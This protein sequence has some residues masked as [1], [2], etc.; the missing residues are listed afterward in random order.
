MRAIHF[1]FGLALVTTP[2][3]AGEPAAFFESKIRPLLIDHCYSCHSSQA[4]KLNRDLRLDQAEGLKRSVAVGKPDESSIIQAVRRN[5]KDVPAMPPDKPMTKEQIA[6]LEE[7]VKTGAYVPTD[8]TPT[9]PTMNIAS[10]KSRWPYA[11]VPEV[12]VPSVRDAN[13]PRTEIDRFILA[14][15][16]S[17]E[18]RPIG[19]ATKQTLIRRANFDLIGLPPTPDEVEAFLADSSPTAFEKVIDRLLASPHYGE[20]WGR[21]WM[22][23]VRYSDTAGDNSDFPIP[24]MVKYRDWI[25]DAI[26]RDLPFDRFAQEQ[27]AGDLIDGGTPEERQQRTIATGYLANARRFGS[28]VSDYPWHL[29]I[30]DTIDNLG[31]AFLG[32]TLNCARCHDHKFDPI[33]MG[34][35]YALY[36]FF[37]STKYPWPGIELEQRQ[38]DLV[39]FAPPDVLKNEVARRD[40][41]SQELSAEIDRLKTEK[42]ATQDKKKQ[43]ELQKKVDELSAKMKME[44]GVPLPFPSAYAV[45]E[46]KSEDAQIQ[47]KGDPKKP[48]EKVRRRFLEVLG[49]SALPP[50]DQS[51]G[52]LAL[53]KWI[54]SPENPLFARVIVNRVWYHHFGR[55]LISTTNDFGKQGSAPTHPELLDYLTKQFL[56][57]GFSMKKLHKRLMLSRVYQIS[58]DGSVPGAETADPTNE[59]LGKFRLRRLDAESIR[60]TLLAVSGNLKTQRPGPHPFPEMTKWNYTQHNP[61]RATYD[62]NHRSVYLMVQR[63]QRHPFLANFDGADTGASTGSRV[64]ST[65]TLQ[66]LYFLNDPFVHEQARAL[67]SSLLSVSEE[68]RIRRLYSVLFTRQPTE[69]EIEKGRAYLSR[70]S[71]SPWESYVRALVRLNEFVYVE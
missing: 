1:L 53:A 47:N 67:A 34:D 70:V 49:G 56:A 17:K 52:R 50:S 25:I 9:K 14:K 41:L 24:Q 71:E 64:T 37:Q 33:S 60:D 58:S 57:E 44:L 7:W 8:A 61:F 36:G 29:T 46:S 48:G 28:T 31:R 38:R 63:I 21:H 18:L 6:F 65:T 35:Y 12:T 59:L 2:L 16:E 51:S 13:W 40:A 20:R 30:E 19:D 54:S 39:V 22:D 26:N 15:L 43:D 68:S 4:K 5:H 55:G 11:K 66:S 42:K 3:R 23:V 45:S 62:H 27:I 69:A 10:E 32:L